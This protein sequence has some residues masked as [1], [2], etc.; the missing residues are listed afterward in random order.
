MLRYVGSEV[1][2]GQDKVLPWF[3]RCSYSPHL[4]DGGDDDVR[5]T[6]GLTPFLL[7]SQFVLRPFPFGYL[8]SI[9]VESDPLQLP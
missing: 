5:K 1:S 9:G 8:G 2:S 4:H 3:L 7:H 6:H